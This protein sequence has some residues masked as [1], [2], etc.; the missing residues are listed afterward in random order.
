MFLSRTGDCYILCLVIINIIN[1]TVSSCLL[2][3]L[4]CVQH[5]HLFSQSLRWLQQVN[6]Q[7]ETL[8]H[9][10]YHLATICDIS[11]PIPDRDISA[12]IQ[13]ISADIRGLHFFQR[14]RFSSWTRMA[15]GDC[16]RTCALV[17]ALFFPPIAVLMV[18]IA[19]SHL[20]KGIDCMFCRNFLPL[21]LKQLQS[22]FPNIAR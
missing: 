20:W 22:L 10:V 12:D 2:S 14:K 8:S 21:I 6:H 15:E 18:Q 11:D 17:F 7:A 5:Q 13:I 16:Y 1:I 3:S 4:T 19:P 9:C